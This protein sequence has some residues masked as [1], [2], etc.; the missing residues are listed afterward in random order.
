MVFKDKANPVGKSHNIDAIEIR[1]STYK[2]AWDATNEKKNFWPS[3]ASLSRVTNFLLFALDDF[4]K[5]VSEVGIPGPD[6]KATVLFAVSNLYDYVAAGSLP[7]WLKP[8][9]PIIKQ[10]IVY[11]LISNAIDWIVNKY[12]GGNWSK[13]AVQAKGVAKPCDFI[14]LPCRLRKGGLK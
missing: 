7:I 14:A 12:Q 13:D 9:S 3:K 2:A 11:V 5:I 10:Y 1:L 8:F 6:K 4:I